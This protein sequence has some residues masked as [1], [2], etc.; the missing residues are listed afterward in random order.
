MTFIIYFINFTLGVL[1]IAFGNERNPYGLVA[2]G[3][4]IFLINAKYLISLF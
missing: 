2:V 4:V 1:L 3:I